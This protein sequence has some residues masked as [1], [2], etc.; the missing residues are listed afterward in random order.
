MAKLQVLPEPQLSLQ[1]MGQITKAGEPVILPVH[2]A[3]NGTY[4]A[5]AD[6]ASGY[7]PV[8]VDVDMTPAKEEGYMNGYEAGAKEGAEVGYKKG[9]QEGYN[10][11]VAEVEAQNAEILTDCNTQ[12]EG[13]GVESAETLEQV[14]NRIGEIKAEPMW[15]P[16]V[17][18]TSGWFYDVTFPE[19]TELV[20]EVP[21]FST[22]AS[23]TF[24]STKGVVSAKL[25][26]RNDI[27]ERATI[28][29]IC[30]Y[31]YAI[32]R[33][34]LSEFNRKFSDAYM[35]FNGCTQLEEIVGVLEPQA[36]VTKNIY[37]NA[38]GSCYKLRKIR[39]AKNS[40]LNDLVLSNSADLSAESIQS[41]IDG[42]ADL[43]GATAQKVI[44]HKDVGAKLTDEQK[45]AISAK[46]WTLVLTQ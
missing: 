27:A 19:N 3:Q 21:N 17:A 43:T 25:I 39:F 42:L 36:G 8:T 1:V 40:I 20:I 46:N 41:I 24:Q 32:K 9:E 31:N 37:T 30:R 18:K 26:C 29:G 22:D 15:L 34:D 2:I 14:P 4:Y 7:N 23:E 5:G 12:L 33:L 13:K 28:T 11:G 6:K 45:V 10:K 16:L 44:F 38:F 35:A